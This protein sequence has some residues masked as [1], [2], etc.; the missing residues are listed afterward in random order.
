MTAGRLLVTA[1]RLVFVNVLAF[2]VCGMEMGRLAC[3]NF[4]LSMIGVLLL[5]C[6]ME[7]LNGQAS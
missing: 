7:I 1:G 2:V 5:F 4:L 6:E 3:D